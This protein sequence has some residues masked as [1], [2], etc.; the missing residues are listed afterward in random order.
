MMGSFVWVMLTAST[1]VLV[2]KAVSEHEV[3][4]LALAEA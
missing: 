1:K 3:N 2:L 4:D